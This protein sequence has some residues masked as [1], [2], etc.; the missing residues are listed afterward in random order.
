[1]MS[2]VR[3]FALSALALGL[4][5]PAAHAVNPLDDAADALIVCSKAQSKDITKAIKKAWSDC[6]A[7][8]GEKKVC[9]QNKRSCKKLCKQT[10]SD[11]AQRKTCKK[12]C[13]ASKK[14]CVATAKASMDGQVCKAANKALIGEL[15]KAPAEVGKC[16]VNELIGK[17]Q[18][19]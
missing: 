3:T 16:S 17:L 13:K 7:L 12:E 5:A 4:L 11:K 10:Y 8:R 19:L 2:I 6:E 1:M 14:A 9:R 15:K 18:K